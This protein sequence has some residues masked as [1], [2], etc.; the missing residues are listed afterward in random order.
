MIS[1]QRLLTL[2]LGVLFATV[3]T[4]QASALYDPGVGRFCSRDPIGYADGASLLR[5]IHSSP[6]NGIDTYGTKTIW[7]NNKCARCAPDENYFED[8]FWVIVAIIEFEL[9]DNVVGVE[10]D[11]ETGEKKFRL[12]DPLREVANF[13][14]IWVIFEQEKYS[15]ECCVK[16]DLSEATLLASNQLDLDN[17]KKY[18]HTKVTVQ[19]GRHG[20]KLT[21]ANMSA[22][23]DFA[24]PLPSFV[25]HSDS[26]PVNATNLCAKASGIANFRQRIK[27]D[28]KIKGGEKNVKSS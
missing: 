26:D 14:S 20:W 28:S 7:Q 1:Q 22:Y 5:Y 13:G 6:H 18:S 3:L 27:G 24:L 15:I 12:K 10:T 11:N 8:S 4:D 25:D 17:S 9:S 2:L 21:R 16:K 19:G 23:V